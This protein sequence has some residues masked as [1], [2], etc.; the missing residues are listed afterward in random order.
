MSPFRHVQTNDS[1]TQGRMLPG[2]RS[3]SLLHSGIQEVSVDPISLLVTFLVAILV[4]AIIW[5][6]AGLA[7]L[8]E[9]LRTILLLVAALLVVLWLVGGRLP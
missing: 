8:P 5:Y 7:G 3:F 9:H 1:D 6:V 4:L 2:R